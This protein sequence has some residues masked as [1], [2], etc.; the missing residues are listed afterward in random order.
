LVRDWAFES[1]FPVPDFDFDVGASGVDR[2]GVE[3][4]EA[5]VDGASEG[6][7]DDGADGC[8]GDAADPV[9]SAQAAAQSQYGTSAAPIPSA[10]ASPA[11]RSPCVVELICFS[12]AAA[13][14]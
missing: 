9:E 5:V 2:E 3:V 11:S 14:V 8:D 7:P 13:M 6:A 1:V 10:T 4:V 12:L